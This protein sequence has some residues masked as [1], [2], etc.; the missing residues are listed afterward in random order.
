MIDTSEIVSFKDGTKPMVFDMGDL[1]YSGATWVIYK[2]ACH[3]KEHIDIAKKHIKRQHDVV[4][5]YVINVD[6]D[7]AKN[8][9]ATNHPAWVE[10]QS[11][12]RN[13]LDPSCDIVLFR[14]FDWYN[15][16]KEYYKWN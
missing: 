14:F 13:A 5:F 7:A 2:E 8:L 4:G 12:H 15:S 16:N 1:S 10:Y 9:V 3:T 11:C 6:T